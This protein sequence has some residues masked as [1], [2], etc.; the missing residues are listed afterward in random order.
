[1]D[2]PPYGSGRQAIL[3]WLE[4]MGLTNKFGLSLASQKSDLNLTLDDFYQQFKVPIKQCLETN[5][6]QSTFPK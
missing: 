2:L 5:I 4:N 6:D 3:R 1:M